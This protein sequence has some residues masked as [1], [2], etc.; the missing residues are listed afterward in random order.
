[1]IKKIKYDITFYYYLPNSSYC[2]TSLNNMQNTK[3]VNV[4]S[5]IKI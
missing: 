4:F 1:M 2:P 5:E 3:K